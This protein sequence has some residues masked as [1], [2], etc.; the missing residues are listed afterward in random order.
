LGEPPS[1]FR[2]GLFSFPE[3]FAAIISFSPSAVT[4]IKEDNL[5]TLMDIYT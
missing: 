4:A 5:I 3:D 2:L 1:L